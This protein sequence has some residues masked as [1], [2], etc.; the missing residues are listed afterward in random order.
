MIDSEAE[1]LIRKNETSCVNFAAKAFVC[2][3]AHAMTMRENESA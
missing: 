1:L 3:F 2:G